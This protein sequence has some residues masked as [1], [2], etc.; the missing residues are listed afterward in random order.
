MENICKKDGLPTD[1]KSK[2]VTVLRDC[3]AK[4]IEVHKLPKTTQNKKST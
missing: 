2:K 3:M 4:H 1:K